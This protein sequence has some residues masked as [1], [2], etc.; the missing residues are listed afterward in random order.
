MTTTSETITSTLKLDLAVVAREALTRAISTCLG[1]VQTCN[2]CA[3][4]C[5]RESDVESMRHCIATDL[6]CAAICETTAGVLSRFD[7]TLRPEIKALLEACIAAC[8]SCGDE[9]A[10]HAGHHAHCKVCADACR[11][12][13]DACRDL[14][15]ELS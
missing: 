14:L 13:E 12:C 9:C 4:A 11:Q 6:D 8:K 5:M 10:S 2:A 7:G 1:C 3:A 15:S